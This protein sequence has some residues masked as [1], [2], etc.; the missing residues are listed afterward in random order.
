KGKST[1]VNPADGTTK[2]IYNISGHRDVSVTACPGQA[3]YNTFPQLRQE[4]ANKIAS[5][6]GATVDHAP[7]T[8]LGL[9]PMVPDPTGAHTLRFGLIFS[10]PVTG[11]APEDFTVG[12]DS[13][14]WTVDKITGKASTY[15][16]W[17]VADE[18]GGGPDDGSVD[19][20]LRAGQV[21]DLAGHA[22]PADDVSSGVAFAAESEP[23][24]ADL[25]LV[26]TR[27]EPPNTSYEIS[28]VFNEPVTGFGLEDIVLGGT[29][30]AAT[31]W[32]VDRYFGQDR[33][34]NFTLY[35]P[36]PA[37]G[38]LTV[39][40]APGGVEDLAGNPGAG[41]DVLQRSIDN[42]APTTSAPTTSLRSGTTPKGSSLRVNLTWSGSDIGP[43]GIASYDV[44]RSYDGHAFTTIASG[45]TGTSFGWALTPGHTYR[46]EVRAR[47]KAGNVSA[48]KAGPTLRPALTQ[49]TSTAVHFSG[50]STTTRLSS[51]SGGSERYLRATGA[52]AT[53]TTTARS[54]SFV[55]TRLSTRGDVKVYIDGVLQSTVD[56][57]GSTAYRFVAFSKTWSSVGT[58]TIKVVSAGS[59]VRV[60]LD[61][62]GVI[63]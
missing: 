31:P 34:Y 24:L 44:A 26:P 45:I 28:M 6:T 18:S 49:Q 25:F 12:G 32:K 21:T 61:A 57:G 1:Y 48:W 19:L 39:Q 62:F 50:S 52:S 27:G 46:F 4:V 14:G 55:T 51:Y 11:L 35:N 33:N 29:S 10:E 37:T 7:P 47:D 20:T 56:L 59:P 60:H 43:A 36:S 53:Y 38:T 40:I 2:L 15:T 42:S 22:G 16:V 9:K 41:S 54:L 13:S 23:P 5:T 8:V 3:F 63:R 17:V 30:Q 58:H